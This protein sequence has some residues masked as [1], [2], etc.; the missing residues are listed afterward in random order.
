MRKKLFTAFEILVWIAI[1]SIPVFFISTILNPDLDVKRH[2]YADF[3]DVNGIITG[4]PV[5]YMGYNIG[6]VY[7]VN[8]L[9]DKVRVDVAIVKDGYVLPQ[10]SIIKVEESGLGGSRSL[11]IFPC[12]NIYTANGRH[13]KAPKRMSEMIDD[14]CQF[15]KALN[16]SM[17]NFLY[18][19]QLNL[20]GGEC[21]K[22]QD[23][24]RQS[25]YSLEELNELNKNLDKTSK[26][27]P[28]NIKNTRKNLEKTLE[29]MRKIKFN[30]Q[31]IKNTA[32]KNQKELDELKTRLN[33]YNPSEYR[34]KTEQ[35]YWK[36]QVIT[37]VDKNNIN[38]NLIQL[39]DSLNSTQAILHS[40]DETFR[41]ESIL[42]IRNKVNG[43]KQ[44]S[45]ILIKED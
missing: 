45:E 12:E 13:T 43:I 15:V 36:T 3:K 44:D 1:F 9:P 37:P 10:C 32:I 16:Q 25:E 38:Q 31:K 22:F 26:T 24:K 8:I 29:S 5:N 35:I 39:N 34:E 2:Y 33:H 7:K 30:P 19:L 20:D 17:G 4:S 21:C 40:I 23:L 42:E 27:A 28:K 18:A 14:F 6:H 41:P 11:E